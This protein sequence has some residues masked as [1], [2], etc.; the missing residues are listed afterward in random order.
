MRGFFSFVA[1]TLVTLVLFMASAYLFSFRDLHAVSERDLE[2]RKVA[3]RM[4]DARAAFNRTLIDAAFDSAYAVYGC[5]ASLDNNSSNASFFTGNFTNYIDWY[6][7]NSSVAFS[8]GIVVNFAGNLIHCTEPFEP[9][10]LPGSCTNLTKSTQP[11][12]MVGGFPLLANV[13]KQ[14]TGF[15]YTFIIS[16]N[17]NYSS[18]DIYEFYVD[19][20]R[21]TL[22]SSTYFG[23]RV[24]GIY[25]NGTQSN[26]TI[27]VK[28]N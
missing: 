2:V 28:C 15:F 14:Y 7:A 4:E 12:G 8:D 11:L 21:T 20:A 17:A 19:L 10:D 25:L 3:E 6:L 24:R 18:F 13:T 27:A 22:G 1:I 26:A 9:D 5:D 16:S 23:V